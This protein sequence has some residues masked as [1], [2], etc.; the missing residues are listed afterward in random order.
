MR[1]VDFDGREIP[2]GEL[3]FLGVFAV[4]LFLACLV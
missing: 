2:K 1:L 4:V 3:V